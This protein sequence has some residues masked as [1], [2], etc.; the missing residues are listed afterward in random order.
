MQ[1]PTI[2]ASDLAIVS[3]ADAIMVNQAWAGYAGDMLN[4]TDPSVLPANPTRSNYSSP[5]W[6]P[7]RPG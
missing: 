4:F 1:M 2:T 5:S 3:N 7:V 6:V